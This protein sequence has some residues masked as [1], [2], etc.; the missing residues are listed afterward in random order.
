MTRTSSRLLP[1]SEGV[2]P[3]EGRPILLRAYAEAK[4]ATAKQAKL[5]RPSEW[6]LV[7][8]CETTVDETQRLRFGTF[9]LWDGDKLEIQGLFFDPR[10]GSTTEAE[11]QVLKAEAELLGCR[12]FTVEDFIEKVLL[13]AAYDGEATVVGFNLPFDLSR[14]ALEV[15]R[16]PPVYRRNKNGETIVDRSMVGGFTMT[17]SKDA[18][19][20]NVKVKHLNRRMAFMNFADPGSHPNRRKRDPADAH[21]RGFFLDLKTLAAALTSESHTLDSLAKF[22]EVP[23]KIKFEDFERPIDAEFIRYA[24][25]DTEVTR[26]CYQ[27]LTRRFAEHGLTHTLPHRI[28]SEASLGKAYLREMGIRPWREV[29]PGFEPEIIGAIMSSYFGGR[30]EVHRRREIVQTLYC[31]F[32]SMYP[33][34]CTLM[35]LWRFVIASEMAHEEATAEV[36]AFL[37]KT[38]VDDLQNPETWRELRVLVQVHPG[39]DI[40]PVRARY[41]S[42]PNAEPIATIGLN[43]LSANQPLWFTLA[44]CVAS[45]LL[46]GKAPKVVKAIRFEPLEPQPAL[47]P[48]AV[49]GNKDYWVDP[50][51]EDFYKRVIDLRRSVQARQK[52]R[53]GEGAD[54]AELKRLES[55]QLALKILANATSYGIFI[56]LNVDEPDE[57]DSQIPLH[58]SAGSRIA[59]CAK[60][61]NPGDFFHPL[62]GTLITGAA[63]LMLAIAE[64]H[65]I[66]EGLDWVFCDTDSMAFAPPEGMPFNLFETRVRKICG[67]FDALNPYEQS[68]PILKLE[69]QNFSTNE[70][71]RKELEPLYCAAISAKRYALFNRDSLGEP[72]IRKA[73]AHGLGHL[74]SPYDDEQSGENEIGVRQ[75]Q[76]DMWKAIVKS[77]GSA[78]PID[79]PIDWRSELAHP[80][81]SQYTASTPDLVARFKDFNLRKPYAERLKPF[82]FLLEF[83]GKRPDEAARQGLLKTSDD[84]KRQLKPISPYSRDP[85]SMLSKIRDRVTGRPVEPRWLRTYAEALRGYHLHPETKFLD[86]DYTDRGRTRRRH[87]L[88]QAIEDIGKEADKWDDEEPL[89]ADN[90]FTVSYGVSEID[91]QTMLAVVRSI[92]K[93]RLA[94]A[95]KVSTRSIPS[96]D[97]SDSGIS[98]GDVRRLFEVASTLADEDRKQESSD[99]ELVRWIADQ[100]G[101]RG[102]TATAEALGYD[103]A[104]LAKVVS[105]QRRLSG[106]LRLKGPQFR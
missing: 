72:I 5:Q 93:R 84:A 96:D 75:W 64:C 83:Y 87:I 74:L 44:D 95:A 39:A 35:G 77:L 22:L 47:R 86:G 41:D 55:E 56:E 50:I 13:T 79:L 23:G 38:T 18:R 59:L 25:T 57:S 99:K 49:N 11:R 31:D 68:G 32:V 73:S 88:V 14:L 58:A 100:V 37:D 48:V 4:P 19:R 29:Q 51:T 66:E 6:V 3:A 1:K 2:P 15:R 36:Q 42:G 94:R 91:R 26:R 30:A 34:V 71:R 90:E 103:V 98:D 65:L 60:R 28:Y 9:Q 85:Y 62:L 69:G 63:R 80:A 106:Y 61:E 101:Q 76:E 10:P 45:K 70:Q 33:T 8:D 92:S 43:Y 40:F 53:A 105:G 20:P 12:L 24:V 7:F 81:V 102:L 52:A 104:N 54:E 16:A 67:W 46:T 21:T 17:V 89:T 97:Q 78:N 82:N 27:E